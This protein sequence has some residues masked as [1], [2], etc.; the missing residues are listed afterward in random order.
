MKQRIW[1][2]RRTTGI[3]NKVK[4]NGRRTRKERSWGVKRRRLVEKKLKKRKREGQ[5]EEDEDWRRLG[6]KRMMMIGKLK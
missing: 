1:N 2:T 5:K 6:K 4:R 3:A